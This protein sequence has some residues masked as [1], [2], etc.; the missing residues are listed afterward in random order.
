MW[1][2]LGC[3]RRKGRAGAEVFD[4]QCLQGIRSDSVR[5]RAASASGAAALGSR[6]PHAAGPRARRASRR[7]AGRGAPGTPFPTSARAP[8][9]H[10]P[11]SSS[12]AAGAPPTASGL[13]LAP[14][15]RRRRRRRGARA[16]AAGRRHGRFGA[17]DRL[18]ERRLPAEAGQ[19]NVSRAGAARDPRLPRSPLL[20]SPRGG[21]GGGAAGRRRG[22]GRGPRRPPPRRLRAAASP[23]RAELLPR[24]SPGF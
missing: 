18:A 23:P 21:G 5:L 16:V 8:V 13:G 1:S 19:P 15:P 2:V 4:R 12:G 10:N 9:S 22:P 11:R 3:G 24:A 6:H 20:G 14:R 7:A 17:G